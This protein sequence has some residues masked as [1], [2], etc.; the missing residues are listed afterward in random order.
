LIYAFEEK[1]PAC[2]HEKKLLESKYSHLTTGP[3]TARARRSQTRISSPWPKTKG[4]PTPELANYGK[5]V[6]TTTPVGRY[7]EG[8]TP[9]GL[10]DMAGNVCEW[11][12]NWYDEDEDWRA[13]RGGSWIY[14][15]GNLRCSARG[16]VVPRI[17]SDGIG[18]RV[19]RCRLPGLR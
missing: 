7:P 18:F 2:T 14:G 3:W 17:G 12:A 9:E 19:V 1:R 16:D 8:A 11:M 5:N 4:Q 10:M 13:L 15:E 6:G